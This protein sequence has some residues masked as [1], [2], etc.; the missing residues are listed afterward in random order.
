MSV[1]QACPHYTVCSMN[2]SN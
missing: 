1:V 2:A